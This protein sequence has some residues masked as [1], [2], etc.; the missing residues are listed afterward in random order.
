MHAHTH[1]HT[2]T[3]TQTHRVIEVNLNETMRRWDQ[4]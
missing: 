4:C 2:H 3:S 1:T